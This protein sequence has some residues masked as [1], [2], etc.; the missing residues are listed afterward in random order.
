MSRVP[1]NRLRWWIA[2]GTA[3]V[4][5]LAGAVFLV[6]ALEDGPEDVVRAYL[7]AVRTA[8]IEAAE[9]YTRDATDPSAS[10]ALLT[11]AAIAHDWS[12]TGVVTRVED[13]DS[14]SV[15]VTFT[16]ADGVSGTG[17]FHVEEDHGDWG[18]TNPLAKVDVSQ[19]PASFAEFNGVTADT[20]QFWL[21]P[22]VYHVFGGASRLLKAPDL[23]AVPYEASSRT[24]QK[25]LP[26]LAFAGGFAEVLAQ[27]V[28][29]WIDGCAASTEVSPPGCPFG[30]DG[31]GMVDTDRGALH[32]TRVE[33]TVLTYPELRLDQQVGGFTAAVFKTGRVGLSGT[34]TSYDGTEDPFELECDVQMDG[35]TLV[36]GPDDRFAFRPGRGSGR[37]RTD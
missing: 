29:A 14:A 17:R 35:F 31:Y 12:V 5:A 10:S 36:Y 28:H 18:I 21:F 24:P 25:Y 26:R 3:A 19:L 23:I 37:C 22:G 34:G 11:G 30:G 15:D 13:E 7:D 32:V 27:Q 20:G 8:D 4:L 1:R 2:A 6:E 16:G 9:P 33:W